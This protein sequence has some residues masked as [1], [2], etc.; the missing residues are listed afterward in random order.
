MNMIAFSKKIF[1]LTTHAL[2]V[3]CVINAHAT[4]L[5][6]PGLSACDLEWERIKTLPPMSQSEFEQWLNRKPSQGI[7]GSPQEGEADYY[8]YLA[9]IPFV[10]GAEQVPSIE[11]RDAWLQKAADAGHKA[12][13]A[14]LMRLRYLGV[15]DSDRMR[16]GL[17]P[18]PLEKPKST[19]QEYLQ[20]VREAAEAGD[21]EFA[22]VMM[23]TAQNINRYLHCQPSDTES[24]DW[25]KDG[26]AIE[27]CDPQTVTTPIETK[28]WAEI[29]A[30]GGNPNAKKLLCRMTYFGTYPQ[31]GFKQDF[32]EAFQWCTTTMQ[33]ACMADDHI[34]LVASMLEQ[35]RGTIKNPDRASQLRKINPLPPI[36]L[37]PI[38]FPQLTR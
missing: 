28:K 22:T 10:I 25:T 29:A 31:L 38:R 4:A 5:R 20:A 14:A 17:Q 9:R 12:A 21:P 23:D 11:Q 26:N 36:F 24:I 1:K 34:G 8:Y 15:L 2:L 30:R 19:R 32:N 18:L 6:V 27:K 37:K 13:K 3:T 16:F 35:G 7:Y 33:T